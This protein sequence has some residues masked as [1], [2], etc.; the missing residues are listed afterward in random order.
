[1]PILENFQPKGQS[2]KGRKAKM[3]EV[4]AKQAVGICYMV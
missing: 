3:A 2:Q 4:L 1:M